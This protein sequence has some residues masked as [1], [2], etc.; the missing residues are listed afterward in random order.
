MLST[1]TL[2]RL[3]RGL[4]LT[5]RKLDDLTIDGGDLRVRDFS[6]VGFFKVKF[7]NCDLRGVSFEKSHLRKVKFVNCDLRGTKFK[8]VTHNGGHFI[9]C[10]LDGA[11]CRY[12]NWNFI[13]FFNVSFKGCHMQS[14]AIAD[15]KVKGCSFDVVTDPNLLR[16]VARHILKDEER[17][18]M[19]VWGNSLSNMAAAPPSE[20][21]SYKPI[22]LSGWAAAMCQDFKTLLNEVGYH[23]TSVLLKF[24]EEAYQKLYGTEED[25]IHYLRRVARITPRRLP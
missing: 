6:R 19:D 25:I 16:D 22:C 15:S 7:I 21:N 12:S 9:N 14:M 3:T 13:T 10:N 23:S 4:T 8:G 11:D 24:G 20:M 2:N 17:L 1:T 18:K 5:V